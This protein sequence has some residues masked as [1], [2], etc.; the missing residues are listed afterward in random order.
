MDVYLR[1]LGRQTRERAKL[2]KRVAGG[3]AGDIHLSPDCPGQ[4]IKI[5]RDPRDRRSYHPKIEAMLAAPPRIPSL[6]HK[7]KERHQV[8]WPR[9]I[10]EAKDGGFLGFA[11][12]EIDFS[13][14]ISLERMLQKRMREKSGLPEFY[15]YRI[16]VAYNLAA[17]VSEL[18]AQGHHIIDMKPV[19]CRIYT[20]SMTLALLDCDGFSIL[21]ENARF[22]A[23]QFTPEYIAPEATGRLPQDLGIEQDLFALAVIIFRLLNNGLHPFQAKLANGQSGGTLQEMI[24]AEY[25][26]YS[27]SGSPFCF[28]ARQSIHESFPTDIR[29]A[30][31]Q[32]FLRENRPT[33]AKWR[34]LLR[35]YADPSSGQL[36]RCDA[37]PKSHAHFGNGCGWC[38]MQANMATARRPIHSRPFSASSMQINP[39]TASTTSNITLS[40]HSVFRSWW[41]V[42]L[43]VISMPVTIAM[44]ILLADVERQEMISS[45][46]VAASPDYGSRSD[47]DI[48]ASE[49]D[50]A[51]DIKPVNTNGFTIKNANLRR[52][53]TTKSEIVITL[54]QGNEVRVL[55]KVKGRNWYLVE[56]SSS[57]SLPSH[58]PRRGYVYGNLIAVI[59]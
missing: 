23:G 3:G 5:Y 29:K 33:A 54:K 1:R 14:S 16:S 58:G 38:H 51:F 53:P 8:A 41:A 37:E 48:S 46:T 11:M 2:G 39:G 45:S 43:A 55:A 4:V 50:T 13:S 26:P 12:P 40:Q 32:A 9:L 17:C 22:E 19:N 18:H 25:Y 24:E 6:K 27:I 52:L 10:A 15:G 31:D 7:G 28:P 57:N 49:A 56:Y 30:F 36:I 59:K 20:D 35:Q 47:P 44:A 42:L 34:D 21:S